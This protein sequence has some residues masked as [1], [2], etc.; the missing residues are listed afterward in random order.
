L[1]LCACVRLRVHV[2]VRACVRVCVRVCVPWFTFLL[3]CLSV[4][5]S[6][7]FCTLNSAVLF[8]H[9]HALVYW[10]SVG[11]NWDWINTHI[12]DFLLLPVLH[13]RDVSRHG[14]STWW[15]LWSATRMEEAQWA[16]MNA[17]RSCTTVLARTK[18]WSW[19]SNCLSANWMKLKKNL[20]SQSFWTLWIVTRAFSLHIWELTSN[21]HMESN[22]RLILLHI[23]RLYDIS[24][25]YN[26]VFPWYHYYGRQPECA[27]KLH[28]SDNTSEV[29]RK[30]CQT[31][32]QRQGALAP[33]RPRAT[34]RFRSSALRTPVFLCF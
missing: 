19:Q 11:R 12:F 29:N 14:C 31:G 9:W 7:L 4:F 34:R 8:C 2:C 22:L 27:E 26:D 25:L 16:K 33:Q 30:G 21:R 18:W 10:L 20:P 32:A 3:L 13:F 6:L 24:F 17:W 5:S 23:R 28:S 1:R 15:N